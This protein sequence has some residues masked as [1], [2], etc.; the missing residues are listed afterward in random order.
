MS[1]SMGLVDPDDIFLSEW[2]GSIL[3]PQGVRIICKISFSFIYKSLIQ[4][5]FEFRLYAL[6]I[7]CSPDYPVKPPIV[8]FVSKINMSSVNQ[9]N[10]LVLSDLPAL[11][12]W[13][14]NG[15]IES[16]LVSLKQLM[17]AP[18]NRRLAQPPEGTN[19]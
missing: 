12:N 6:R 16:I 8:R 13:N 4:T 11:A 17:T 9:S 1:V 5:I 7:S 15:T 2:N 14:R 18:N 10:G 19:F 3:G